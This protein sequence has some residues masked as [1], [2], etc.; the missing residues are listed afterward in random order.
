MIRS[1]SAATPSDWATTLGSRPGPSSAG[2]RG[3]SPSESPIAACRAGSRSH[4]RSRRGRAS[5]R[6]RSLAVGLPGS[7]STSPSTTITNFSAGA[8]WRATTS[9]ASTSTRWRLPAIRPT[10][11]SGQVADDVVDVLDV[12]LGAREHLGLAAAARIGLV[13]Q[14]DVGRGDPEERDV[15]RRRARARSGTCPRTARRRV[16]SRL[17]R[18]PRVPRRIPA[19][20]CSP[21]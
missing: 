17:H 6:S 16:R 9:P 1:K 5:R 21:R 13:D 4:R 10:S 11:S 18:A 14:L 12:V 15:H 2:S 19:A 20:R 7:T 3:F 8:P